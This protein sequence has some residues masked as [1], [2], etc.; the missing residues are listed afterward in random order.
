MVRTAL[1]LVMF[2]GLV[3]AGAGAYAAEPV[4]TITFGA[5]VRSF[6]TTALLARPEARSIVVPHDVA[7]RREA[8]YRAVPLLALLDGLPLDHA[9]T[10]AAR[11]TDGYVAQLPMAL[12]RKAA[13]GGA[14]PWLAIEEPGSP[15]PALPGKS[16]SAGPFYLVWIDPER[17]SIGKEQWTY[18]LAALAAV[19]APAQRWPQIAVDPALPA[20]A[21]ERRGQALLIFHCLPCHRVRGGGEGEMGPDLVHP[22][23]PTEYMSAEGLKAQ[24]RNPKSL[25]SWPAQQMP[26]FDET[27]LP[28]ADIDAIVA[29]LRHMAG[30]RDAAR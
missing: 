21:I 13:T 27:A 1:S 6:D 14:V 30:R 8:S 25:R 23:S 7:Y 3:V 12:L 10:I 20:E 28:A 4:L 2:A 18:A 15:W 26:S 17:S 16:F 9:E 5:E 11:A 24:I 19:E 22:H 29:Y